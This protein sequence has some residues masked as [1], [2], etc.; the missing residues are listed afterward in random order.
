MAENTTYTLTKYAGT[1]G[2]V[3]GSVVF[4][5]TAITAADYVEIDVGFQPRK[6][7]WEN[8]TDR[9]NLV[10]FKGM[11][12]ESAV[13]T[14]AAGT[15]TLEVTGVNKGITLTNR[16]FRVAQNVALG[17]IAASKTC[18]FVALP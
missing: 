4:D 12:D 5:G 14:A 13:K 16:G 9:V 6:V 15:R 7:E 17:A 2:T 18:Y 1:A 10:H 11:A 8:A 3:Q